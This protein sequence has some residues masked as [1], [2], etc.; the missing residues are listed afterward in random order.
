MNINKK[1][2]R[3]SFE[4]DVPFD[5][6][7][8]LVKGGF[9]GK[10]AYIFAA[11]P[12]INDVD[13]DK[14]SKELK[15]NLVICIKQ[16][17]TRVEEFCDVLLMNFCNFNDYEWSKIDCPVIWTSF[18]NNHSDIIHEKGIK[19]DALLPVV[20]NERNNF[21][22]LSKSTAG[23]KAWDN[24]NRL[25][26][27]KAIWG[28]GLMYELAIPLAINSGVEKICLVGWDI[29]KKTGKDDAF[30][31]EHFYE[32]TN[33]SMK[34]KITDIEVDIVSKS[35]IHLKDWLQE[36]GIELTVTSDK[37]LVHCG[38]KRENEWLKKRV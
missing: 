37:S 30:L 20:E 24:F 38:V 1:I 25:E 33:V 9:T 12:S 8:R 14:L 17:Y 15:S 26:E 35:T 16:S 2:F 21:A 6:K 32:N 3:D 10:K 22:G 11:G 29:G 36:Q 19:C 31:N 4:L 23:K 13:F 28:P 5:T 27:N 34:T 18:E 7:V